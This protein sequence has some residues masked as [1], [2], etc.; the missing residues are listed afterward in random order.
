MEDDVASAGDRPHEL[1]VAEV[2]LDQLY[3]RSRR[4]ILRASIRQV[5]QAHDIVPIGHKLDRQSGTDEA[6][7]PRD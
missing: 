4:E 7:G 1:L 2:T 3:L 5:V 6:S